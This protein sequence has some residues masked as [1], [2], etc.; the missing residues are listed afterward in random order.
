MKQMTNIVCNH[1][2]VLTEVK[3]FTHSYS[4]WLSE[5]HI[6]QSFGP[7]CSVFVLPD[8]HVHVFQLF[9]VVWRKRTIS[10]CCSCV[11]SVLSAAFVPLPCCV[12]K[13]SSHRFSPKSHSSFHFTAHLPLPDSLFFTLII[14]HICSPHHPACSMTSGLS[15]WR[16]NLAFHSGSKREVSLF[17]CC[18]FCFVFWLSLHIC[19]TFVVEFSEM[20]PYVDGENFGLNVW[21]DL[22]FIFLCRLK[23][24][25]NP[26]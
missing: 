16:T 13:T 4:N 9:L 7:V 18:C 10:W 22:L 20:F 24:R 23:L 12:R 3:F 2:H 15:P 11:L 14:P 8:L 19:M 6:V 21:F 17:C 25:T 26:M 1:F 5:A